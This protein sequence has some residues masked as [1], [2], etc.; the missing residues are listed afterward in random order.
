MNLPNTTMPSNEAVFA[1]MLRKTRVVLGQSA[2]HGKPTAQLPTRTQYGHRMNREWKDFP[3]A[4]C[5]PG[6]RT[7][8]GCDGIRFSNDLM[9]NYEAVAGNLPELDQA[10]PGHGMVTVDPERDTPQVLAGYVPHFDKRFIGLTGG[11]AD[12]DAATVAAAKVTYMEGYLWDRPEA[13][14]ALITRTPR[15]VIQ[16][17][18]SSMSA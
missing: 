16:S 10:A 6:Y 18:V 14:E 4:L 13:K 1:D 9:L 11:A 2:Y 17:I 3:I 8:T 12:I 5:P 15:E 7:E